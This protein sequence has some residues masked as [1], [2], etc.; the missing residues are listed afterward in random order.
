MYNAGFPTYT[1]SWQDKSGASSSTLYSADTDGLC[2]PFFIG[3]AERGT[4]GAINF[5]AAAQLQP[6]YGVSTFTAGS[7]YYGPSTMFA[8]AAMSIQGIEYMRLVDPLA[9]TANLG[10]F[11]STVDGQIVQYQVDS[12]GAR[13][14]D[15]EGDYIPLLQSDGTTTLTAPGVIVTWS[16]RPLTSEETFDTLATVTQSTP[17]TGG[18]ATATAVVTGGAVTGITPGAAGGQ[19]L[20]A[21]IVTLTGG[22]GTGAV[23]T[24]EINSSGV[25]TGYT[26]VSGGTG[27]TSAPSVV[28]TPAAIQT[29]IYPILGLEVSS[30]GIYGN[31][32]GF[33][34]YSTGTAGAT[35]AQ[36]INSALYRFAP[37]AL[38]LA[39][40][41][42]A[43]AIQDLYG[44]SYNDVSFKSSAVY[45][46][47]TTNYAFDYVLGY[48][49][50]NSSTGVSTLPY[51][52]KT[53]GANIGL[54]GADVIAATS[55]LAGTDPYLIDLISGQD[56]DGNYYDRLEVNPASDLVVSSS[57]IQYCKGGT[58]GDTSDAKLQEMIQTWISSGN[59]GEFPNL[60]QHPMTHMSDPGWTMNTKLAVI[61]LLDARDN[62]KIDL[63][64]QD[65]SLPVNTQAQDISAGVTLMTQA[66]L[67]PESTLN[68]VGCCRVSIYAHAGKLVGGSNYTGLVPYTFDRMV[69]RGMY[70]GGTYIKGS[71]AGLPNS[72]VTVFQKPNWVADNDTVRALSWADRLNVVQHATRTVV[73]YPSLRTVYANDTSL[74]SDDE[75]TDRIMYM[76]KICRTVWAIFAGRREDPTK[77]F[78]QIEAEISNRIKLAFGNDNLSVVPTVSQTAADANLGY[79]ITVNLAVTGNMPIRQMNFDVVVA[80]AAAS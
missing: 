26:I 32:Q 64:T 50:T 63:S 78:P 7:A 47:T 15:G 5:G 61:N 17:G 34:L 59:L 25:V 22:G 79:A 27:Y 70:D 19:Y 80:R 38:A 23:V 43:T 67:H 1:F 45:S 49:Y 72:Q 39:N 16:V 6:I 9:N 73:F 29:K 62:L 18:G 77:L 41:T 20:V 57:A 3:L 37:M 44:S 40:S 21:P 4:P 46:G 66:Q 36:N 13:T 71:T 58:D 52:I 35:V 30:P 51:N 8:D 60:S 54:I 65:V 14:I 75:I 69:K 55:S 24:T 2:V 56:L 33:M 74:L 10:L 12:S 68:A 48:N 11:C 42:T 28:V 76:F 31:R 53:Y